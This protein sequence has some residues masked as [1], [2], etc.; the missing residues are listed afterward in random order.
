MYSSI[1][2]TLITR[3][4]IFQFG[5]QYLSTWSPTKKCAAGRD[6]E[7]SSV[8]VAVTKQTQL[9]RSSQIIVGAMQKAVEQTDY[10]ALS[11]RLAAISK[12]YIPSPPLQIDE[13]HYEGYMEMHMEYFQTLK[14]ISRRIHSKIYKTIHNSFPVMNYGTYLRAISIDLRVNNFLSS[15][16]EDERALQ[17]V[18]LGCGSDLRMIPI[19]RNFPNVTYIDIDYKD[20]VDLKKKVLEKSGNLRHALDLNENGESPRYK[21][22]SCDLNNIAQTMGILKDLT[23]PGFPTVIITEC[24]LCYMGEKESQSLIDGI[25]NFYDTGMWVSYDPIGGSKDKDRFGLIMQSNL[26]ESRH[27]E[28]PTLMVFNSKEAYSKRFSNC[29]T[30]IQNMWEIFQDE[31]P[32]SEIARLKTLQFLDEVEEL[33]IMQTHYVLSK[34]TWK[35]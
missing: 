17:I 11:C 26:R 14:T 8:S 28:M 22:V 9:N 32:K 30:T 5:H 1:K 25:S 4:R 3:P 29:D 7:E 34:A 15:Y 13:C 16:Q 6:L 35:E 19:L 31:I 10:D 33:E 27:L 18:N 24:V 2:N 12:G 23:D 21:L 20:S